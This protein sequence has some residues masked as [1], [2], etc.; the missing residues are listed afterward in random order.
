MSANHQIL[1]EV[2]TDTRLQYLQ[3][4]ETTTVGR[5]EVEA[6]IHEV[7]ARAYD[8]NVTKY[9]PRLLALRNHQNRILAA[10]GMQNAADANL[11]LEQY[12]DESVDVM[13]SRL[14]GSAVRREEIIEIGNLAS[15]HRGG[16]QHLIVAMT[17]YLS[18]LG[19]KWVVFTA[20]PAVQKAFAAIGLTLVP[21]AVAEKHRLGDE[22]E[23]WG[24]YYESGPIVVA[25]RV[26]SAFLRLRDA[27]HQESTFRA[28]LHLWEQAFIEG[29]R[30]RTTHMNYLPQLAVGGGA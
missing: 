29:F 26:E 15:I 7:F 11:F 17:A 6:F 10:L 5:D 25:T 3:L 27:V 14:L 1:S 9:L 23:Q 4:L 12:L 22:Q 20:V 30:T 8:A 18:G 19:S 28:S 24:S 21:L 2:V 13:L 16:L